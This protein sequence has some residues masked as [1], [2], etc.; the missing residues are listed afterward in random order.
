MGRTGGGEIDSALGGSPRGGA[1][2]RDRMPPLLAGDGR[3]Q[4]TRSILTGS[5]VCELD[6]L[7]GAAAG[8]EPGRAATPGQREGQGWPLAE[9][10]SPLN[11][12]ARHVGV[13]LCM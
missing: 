12:R 6:G 4:A 8:S 11:E 1:S 3:G 2:A 10:R 9:G 5:F 7:R 13:L